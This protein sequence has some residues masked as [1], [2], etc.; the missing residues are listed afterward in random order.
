MIRTDINESINLDYMR[1]SKIKE[2]TKAYQYFD[3][4]MTKY[5]K[6][7]ENSNNEKSFFEA[8]DIIIPKYII[9]TL[10]DFDLMPNMKIDSTFDE[11]YYQ[12]KKDV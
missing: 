2:L 7:Y 3:I 12:F 11:N 4:I 8:E 6:Y 9:E 10:I 5:I 1:N